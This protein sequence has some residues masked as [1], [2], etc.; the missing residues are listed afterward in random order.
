MANLSYSS[1]MDISSSKSMYNSLFIMSLIRAHLDG[2]AVASSRV[3]T[4][5][6]QHKLLVSLSQLCLISQW[7][8][9]EFPFY[10]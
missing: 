3:R 6:Y 10:S 2:P 9:Q 8:L 1:S 5:E 7:Y 4:T